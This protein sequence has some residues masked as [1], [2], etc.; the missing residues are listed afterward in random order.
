MAF[1]SV[2]NDITK[3]MNF[4]NGPGANVLTHSMK[5]EERAMMKQVEKAIMSTEGP[6]SMDIDQTANENE[7]WTKVSRKK[8]SKAIANDP[9]PMSMKKVRMTL[10]IRQPL[11]P[12]KPFSPAKLHI[13]TLHEIHKFD[14]S[15]IVANSVGDKR[16][17]IESE[18]METKYKE[19]F[20]PVEKHFGRGPST[21]SIS[22]DIYMTG[23]ANECKEA[24]FPFLKKNRIFIYFNPKPGLEHFTSIGVLFG[25]NP[26]TTWRDQLADL[27]IETMKEEVTDEEKEK[28]GITNDGS[29]KIILSLNIQSIEINKPTETTSVALEIRVPT[30][31]ERLYTEIIER[32]YEK[33]ENQELIIPNKLGKFSSVLP[34]IQDARG[35][36]ILDAT[37]ECRYA[38]QHSNSHFRIHARRSQSTN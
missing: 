31:I 36:L 1:L 33:A 38:Q 32:L 3:P 14:E 19:N 37:T 28:L 23:K 17:N 10:S 26:D 16:I 24:I 29:P 35:L 2:T 18:M 4:G 6:H 9:V 22:H 5:K 15:L 25:P 13:N 34:K 7:D 20:K 8:D 30:G 11:D 27:L 12:S 21:V